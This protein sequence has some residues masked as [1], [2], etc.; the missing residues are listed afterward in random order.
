MTREEAKALREAPHVFDARFALPRVDHRADTHDGIATIEQ[1]EKLKS[2][3]R[4]Q[5]LV[6]GAVPA[7]DFYSSTLVDQINRFDRDAVIRQAKEY[8]S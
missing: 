3:D 4:D 7:A 1:W 8:R 5:K 6:E 2:V